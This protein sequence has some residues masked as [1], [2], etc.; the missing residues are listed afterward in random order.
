MKTE[1]VSVTISCRGMVRHLRCDL[2]PLS[3]EQVHAIISKQVEHAL[4]RMD[5]ERRE[6]RDNQ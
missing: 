1:T 6:A 5:Y 4:E 3:D 2:P